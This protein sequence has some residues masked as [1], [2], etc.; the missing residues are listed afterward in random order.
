MKLLKENSNSYM[1]AFFYMDL[2]FPFYDSSMALYNLSRQNLASFIH[3]YIHF[4]Q[5]ITTYWGLNNA[6]V[7][8]EYIHGSINQIY[9]HPKGDFNVPLQLPNNLNNIEFNQ[10]IIEECTGY[11]NEIDPLFIIDV[12]VT[13]KKIKYP[14]PYIKEFEHVYLKLPNRKIQFGARAIMESMAYLLE[15]QI[16]PG[17]SSVNE[18]PYCSA[19]NIALKEYPKFAKDPLNILAL[20]DLSLQFSNPAA[21]FV[22]TLRE[23]KGNH[24]IPNKA[25]DL[26]DLFYNRPCI[27]M[28]KKCSLIQ[29]LFY[30]GQ[31]VRERLKTY[32]NHSSFKSFHKIIDNL[33]ICGLDY[34]INQP[35]FILDIAR[36]GN[37]LYNNQMCS[38]FNRT[39]SPII[40]DC[41]EEYFII[42]SYLLSNEDLQFFSAIEQILNLLS[43]G[44]DC[45]DM[46]CWCQQ[47]AH[48]KVIIDDRCINSPWER[49]TD[50]NL[51]PYGILWKHWNLSGYRPLR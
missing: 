41:N 46:V 6:Y 32:L 11:Y 49:C 20:C 3:E 48:N 29:S 28:N 7:Y 17:G 16:A 5:D 19:E 10:S 42:N 4:L 47:S 8:S 9:K 14:N 13:K 36:S 39:G 2:K 12:E 40:K 21:I 35:T 43:R 25:E 27:Q 44:D 22:K 45:C 38:L 50:I 26:Y 23:F 37:A 31:T 24:Y 1:P 34:R 18:Y 33:I 51:C 30:L 15:R